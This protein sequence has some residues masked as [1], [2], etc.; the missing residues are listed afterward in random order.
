MQ[1]ISGQT[2]EGIVCF[3]NLILNVL[4]VQIFTEFMH[5][6]D[7]V[8]GKTESDENTPRQPTKKH[9][10]QVQFLHYWI[11]PYRLARLNCSCLR[12]TF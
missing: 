5:P 12:Y 11:V 10:L 2:S 9:S 4:F 7:S 1:C 6:V 8:D 3:S